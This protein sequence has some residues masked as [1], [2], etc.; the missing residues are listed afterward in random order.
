ME[1]LSDEQLN[2]INGG[3]S[4]LATTSLKAI[5]KLL[6]DLIKSNKDQKQDG[7]EMNA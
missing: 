5:S 4:E 2:S 1:K 7:P 3:M 6:L